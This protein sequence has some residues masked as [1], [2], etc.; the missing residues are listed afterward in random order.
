MS[1]KIYP[2]LADFPYLINVSEVDSNVVSTNIT[3][4]SDSDTEKSLD[5]YM[6][7]SDINWQTPAEFYSKR[8]NIETTG[9][10]YIDISKSD[11]YDDNRVYF[12]IEDLHN[13]CTYE[14]RSMDI[15][16]AETN[17]RFTA[18][19]KIQLRVWN[20]VDGW[21]DINN[22]ADENG[23]ISRTMAHLRKP[24]NDIQDRYHISKY[25]DV[26]VYKLNGKGNEYMHNRHRGYTIA[27]TA[28][29]STIP[30]ILGS[31]DVLLGPLKAE[32]TEPYTVING[33]RLQKVTRYSINGNN[34]STKRPK[35]N[36]IHMSDMALNTD[37]T[38]TNARD[39]IQTG[40][41]PVW[42][43]S[44]DEI[45]LG[46]ELILYSDVGMPYEWRYISS[47]NISFMGAITKIPFKPTVLSPTHQT[48]DEYRKFTSRY[49]LG[50]I[51]FEFVKFINN[52]CLESFGDG[53][54]KT[55]KKD[56][57]REYNIS[58]NTNMP[59]NYNNM[60]DSNL[61]FEQVNSND[62][63]T[64]KCSFKVNRPT[65][66]TNEIESIDYV[67]KW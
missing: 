67:K 14:C 18:R 10:G 23:N 47:D 56:W 24:L 59:S 1:I 29:L 61:M 11:T 63:N 46:T 15:R 44:T 64:M 30:T 34:F 26:F 40:A 49:S 7:D 5:E 51:P 32:N 50:I 62:T 35:F 41:A 37:Y 16:C 3:T 66:T 58:N 60:L 55:M 42:R 6:E 53:N 36:A 17:E 48:Y 13:W 38:T 12:W 8:K 31:D 45:F 52:K 9:D 39:F 65:I 57:L 54:A 4:S 28:S 43:M 22:T 2:K 19:I 21:I 20:G 33:F 25:Q 27:G